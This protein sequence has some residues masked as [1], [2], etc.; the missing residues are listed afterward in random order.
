LTLWPEDLRHPFAFEPFGK[1][2]LSPEDFRGTT[3]RAILSSVTW[4]LLEALGATPIFKDNYG[5]DVATGRIQGAESGL[6]AGYF[7]PVAAIATG[8]V[9]FFPKFQV[10]FANAAAFE[11]LSEEQRSVLQEA[12]ART[13]E[14]AI[15][16]H[17]RQVDAA[18]QWCEDGGTIVM[19][20]DEQ[21]AAFEEAARPVFDQIEQDPLN[22]ELIAAIRE[23]KA[24][25][26]PSPGAEACGQA[27]AQQSPEPSAETEVWSEGPPPNGVW[28]VELTTEDFVQRGV[29]RSVA[30]AEWAGVYTLTLEDSKSIEVWHGIEGQ[31]GTCEAT[32]EV[33]GDVVHFTYDSSPTAVCSRDDDNIQW[34]LDDDGLHLHLADVGKTEIRAYLEAKP[35]QKIN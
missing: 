29:L 11:G 23:L 2:F 21:L 28:Q 31:T 12:A 20:S 24:S 7:L 35:W 26:E 1:T 32:Y 15:A 22:A 18:A 13:Q 17:P 25:T 5:T 14:R 27:A 34:R 9:V 30:E 16:E 3:I 10:L 4:A 19:A 6:L 8:N 33:V